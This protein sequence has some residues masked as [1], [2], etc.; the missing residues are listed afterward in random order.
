[1][2]A[3]GGESPLAWRRSLIALGCAGV[4]VVTALWLYPPYADYRS[5]SGQ[6][7]DLEREMA[8]L[9]VENTGL[10][11]TVAALNTPRGVELKLREQGWVR[12]NERVV[13]TVPSPARTAPE[14]AR[15]GAP[16]EPQDLAGRVASEVALS[17]RALGADD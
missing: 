11:S 9:Q 17:L 1:M 5:V 8:S 6:T 4:F 13:R 16:S 3:P 15:S 7:A 10:E 12:T 14:A 2:P